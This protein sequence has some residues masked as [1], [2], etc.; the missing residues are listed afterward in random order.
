MFLK[1]VRLNL[2]VL[3]GKCLWG[4]KFREC[5]HVSMRSSEIITPIM[6]A[7]KLFLQMH[8]NF[9]HLHKTE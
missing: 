9:L 2:S 8:N 1:N 3:H 6:E 7:A 5:V 4:Q